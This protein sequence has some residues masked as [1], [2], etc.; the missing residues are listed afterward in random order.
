MCG[1]GIFIRQSMA[2]GVKITTLCIVTSLNCIS[3][4]I[5]TYIYVILC[6][7]KTI[8]LMS[9][10]TSLVLFILSCSLSF[11]V[12]LPHPS[13]IK[14][15]FYF[16]LCLCVCVGKCHTCACALGGQSSYECFRECW[17]T[18]SQPLEKQ[19]A[20]LNSEPSL[21]PHFRSCF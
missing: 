4:Y 13:S 1:T 20:L 16:H 6:R 17:Q 9:F 15:H 11:S 8:F 14:A 2:L 18:D 12:A 21:Q 3:M 19:N 10:Q 5:H 7:L